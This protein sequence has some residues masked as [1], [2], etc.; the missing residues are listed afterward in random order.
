MTRRGSLAYYLAAWVCGCCFMT[1]GAWLVAGE[2]INQ[3]A[4]GLRSAAGF[5]V[6]YFFGLIFGLFPSLLFA[7]LLRRIMTGL[8]AQRLWVWLLVGAALAYPMLAGL[9]WIGRL[10][11]R[12]GRPDGFLWM[13]L[14]AGYRSWPSAV[15]LAA[16]PAATATSAVLFS[17]HRA[18]SQKTES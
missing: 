2:A 10:P 15:L 1:L 3:N 7:F 11:G 13:L 8:G 17:V 14:F 18:F 6:L 16:I 12:F 4:P 9:G 5:L